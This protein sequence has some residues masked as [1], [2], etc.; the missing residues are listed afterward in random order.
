[1]DNNE[2]AFNTMKTE[3]ASWL[4]TK[5]TTLWAD[6]MIND[7]DGLDKA[8]EWF[9]RQMQEFTMY[10]MNPSAFQAAR[11]PQS[12]GVSAGWDVVV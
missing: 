3:I 2:Y 7:P 4:S 1:M 8:A 9:G 5:G 12:D 11:Q 6:W 10:R